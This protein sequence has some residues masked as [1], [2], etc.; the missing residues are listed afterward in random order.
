MTG[1]YDASKGL[2]LMGNGRGQF[3]PLRLSQSGLNIS[4]DA[5]ATS[6]IKVK[7]HD[8]LLSA[9]N[10]SNLLMYKLNK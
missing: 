2:V 1:R 9:V 4:G 6:F 8:V 10:G 3:K 5:R 7:N